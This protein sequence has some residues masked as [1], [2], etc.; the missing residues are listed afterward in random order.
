MNLDA[1]SK[2]D[3]GFAILNFRAAFEWKTAASISFRLFTCRDAT[4][5]SVFGW[6]DVHDTNEQWRRI[7]MRI[8]LPHTI[9]KLH[10]CRTV[11]DTICENLDIPSDS[12]EASFISSLKQCSFETEGYQEFVSRGA[13]YKADDNPWDERDGVSP[14]DVIHREEAFGMLLEAFPDFH[15]RVDGIKRNS[16]MKKLSEQFLG[17]RETRALADAIDLAIA[18]DSKAQLRRLF[19]LLEKLVVYGDYYTRHASITRMFEFLQQRE[20]LGDE[21]FEYMHP[22]TR[23]KWNQTA[24]EMVRWRNTTQ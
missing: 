23:E 13:P 12:Y 24:E 20:S 9:V 15:E 8:C 21:L 22:K 11:I 6:L 10:D 7:K 19:E 2:H 3:D 18:N 4:V 14:L 1:F 17:L 5:Q 16:L